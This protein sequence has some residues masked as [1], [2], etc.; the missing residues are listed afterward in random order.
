MKDEVALGKIFGTQNVQG[1]QKNT[2]TE[3]ES[4]IFRWWIYENR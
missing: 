3:V 4:A 2:D 1:G